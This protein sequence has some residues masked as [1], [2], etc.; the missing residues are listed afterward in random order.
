MTYA[1]W[2]EYELYWVVGGV[3]VTASVAYGIAYALVK[4]FRR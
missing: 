1:T 4:A 2:S 3:I